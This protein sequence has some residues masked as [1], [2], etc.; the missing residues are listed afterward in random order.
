M[1]DAKE[2]ETIDGLDYLASAPEG[3]TIIAMVESCGELF[4]ATDK[5]LYQFADKKRLEQIK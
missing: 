2:L 5:H 3:E 1:R 4:V